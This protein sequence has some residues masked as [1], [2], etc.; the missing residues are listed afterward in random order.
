MGVVESRS[1]YTAELR[2]LI[3]PHCG[4]PVD[5]SIEGGAVRCSFCSAPLVV[6]ARKR[7]VEVTVAAPRPLPEPER[8]RRLRAQEERPLLPP[9]GIA[10]VIERGAIPP[11]RA[12]EARAA[13]QSARE[14][15][16]A[17]SLEAAEELVFLNVVLGNQFL[18]AKDE[19]RHR[20]MLESALEAFFL[21]RH[22]SIVAAELCMGACRA[23]DA[24]GATEWLA[25]TDPTAEDLYTDSGYRLARASVAL[26]ARDFDAMLA[27]LGATEASVPVHDAFDAT[28]AVHRAHALEHLGRRGDAADA[29]RDGMARSRATRE[30]IE[31]VVERSGMASATL[32]AV[33]RTEATWK[34]L[35]VV[36]LVA[37]GVV[38]VAV[39]GSLFVAGDVPWLPFAAFGG[40]GLAAVA[41][42][43]G[44]V[45]TT[46][47]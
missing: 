23:G 37:A 12:E 21:P 32:A 2:V 19:K 6:L 43:V 36:S 34:K 26:L 4:A 10:H 33:R 8:L 47:R 5:V 35:G 40:A 14:R 17:K 27:A 29:L 31:R 24:R 41:L 30:T 42:A 44:L 18:A 9:P 46:R 1:V 28:T 38:M 39:L 15:T 25:H 3:C 20:A 45:A 16:A 22:R 11:W 13:W 7:A